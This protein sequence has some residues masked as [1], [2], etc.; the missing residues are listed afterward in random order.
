LSTINTP[1][2]TDAVITAFWNLCVCILFWPSGVASNQLSHNM[3]VSDTGDCLRGL[4][5]GSTALWMVS[6]QLCI[7]E[8]VACFDPCQASR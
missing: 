1:Q 3:C 4:L 8:S 2:H 5:H 7:S 6:V